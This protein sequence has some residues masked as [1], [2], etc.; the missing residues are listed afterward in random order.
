MLVLVGTTDAMI[1][2]EMG[3]VYREKLPNCHYILVYDS[4]DLK[5]GYQRLVDMANLRV[6]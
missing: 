4:A 6:E 2:A 1:P 3:R 5:W